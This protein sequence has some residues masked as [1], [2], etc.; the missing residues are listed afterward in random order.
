LSS[1]LNERNAKFQLYVNENKAAIFSPSKF[2]DP[3]EY[4]DFGL[5]TPDLKKT[6]QIMTA[7]IINLGSSH[8]P[9]KGDRNVC[10]IYTYCIS[11]PNSRSWN[12]KLG[13]DF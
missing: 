13:A 12:L 4:A 11:P 1:F 3:E 5:R 2:M 6:K 9:V 10:F 8:Y 7:I